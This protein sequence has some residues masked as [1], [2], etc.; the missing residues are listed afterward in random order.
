MYLINHDSAE[1][2]TTGKTIPS[3]TNSPP[4][5]SNENVDITSSAY[6]P[7]PENF[8]RVRSKPKYF[9]SI[10]ISICDMVN[11]PLILTKIYHDVRLLFLSNFFFVNHDIL[12]TNTIPP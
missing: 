6:D 2:L 9:K 12:E 11:M 10:R 7:I 1:T 3:G 5:D 4:S 8:H